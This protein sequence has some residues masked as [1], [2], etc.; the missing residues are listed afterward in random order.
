M[1]GHR[2]GAVCAL[3]SATVFLCSRP[4]KSAYSAVQKNLTTQ[5]ETRNLINFA[6]AAAAA[7]GLFLRGGGR[8]QPIPILRLDDANNE[9]NSNNKWNGRKQNKQRHVHPNPIGREERKKEKK[10]KERK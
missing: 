10:R 3:N 7:E 5:P 2:L 9:G 6:A 4:L 1:V 8:R